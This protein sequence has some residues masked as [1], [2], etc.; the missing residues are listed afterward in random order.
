ME[1]G[2][3]VF[4]TDIFRCLE[5]KEKRFGIQAE[6]TAKIAKLVRKRKCRLYEVGISYHSRTYQEGKKIGFKDL[7]SALRSIIQHNIIQ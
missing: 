4:K 2:C 6:I 7:F 3:K 1:T 5:I